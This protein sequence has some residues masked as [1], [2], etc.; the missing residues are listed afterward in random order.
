LSTLDG[1]YTARCPRMA[2]VWQPPLT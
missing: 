1:P 2:P